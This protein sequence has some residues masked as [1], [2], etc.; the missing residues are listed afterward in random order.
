MSKS[1]QR[2][3]P[4]FMF[5]VAQTLWG[6]GCGPPASPVLA[7]DLFGLPRDTARIDLTV[8]WNGSTG[9]AAFY[10]DG[11]NNYTTAIMM[12][13]PQDSPPQTSLAVDLPAGT[14]GKVILRAESRPAMMMGPSDLGDSGDLAGPPTP[15]AAAAAGCAIVNLTAGTLTKVQVSLMAPPPP[16]C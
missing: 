7:A 1:S 8:T 2:R 15:P 10:R 14:T 13:A 4:L 12:P 9:S 6:W 3:F 11:M 5:F 16:P